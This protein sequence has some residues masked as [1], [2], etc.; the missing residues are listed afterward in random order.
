MAWRFGGLEAWWCG[1]PPHA[2]G[3]GAAPS[4]PCQGARLPGPRGR[5]FGLPLDDGTVNGEAPLAGRR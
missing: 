2:P 3:R 4:G 5:A 1:A